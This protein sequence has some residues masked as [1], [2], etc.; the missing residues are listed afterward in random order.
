MCFVVNIK[1]NCILYLPQNTFYNILINL[2]QHSFS[3]TTLRIE[4]N[5]AEYKGTV[6][7]HNIVVNKTRMLLF[8]S[9]L[10]LTIVL[11][12]AILHG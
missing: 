3:K 9:I 8:Y 7:S 6:E 5:N 12:S 4:R 2:L 1:Y 10:Y 11:A